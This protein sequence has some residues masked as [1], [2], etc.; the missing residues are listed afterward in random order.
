MGKIV[1]LG[2][3]PSKSNSY[4]IILRSFK[5]RKSYSIGKTTKLKRYEHAFQLQCKKH[6]KELIDS[7]FKIDLDV[8][9]DSKRPDLD[10]SLKIILDCL[11]AAKMIKND[12][13][14]VQINARK[15]KDKTNP[16]IEFSVS[17]IEWD[18]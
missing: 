1:I 9:Y 16:R 17:R 5:G 15:F 8:Y 10:N 6:V 2:N 7:E 11:Q 18:Y 4:K 3:V 14:C 13:K 12:N